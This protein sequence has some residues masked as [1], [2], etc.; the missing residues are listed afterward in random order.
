M[1]LLVN[2]SWFLKLGHDLRVDSE[3]RY[4]LIKYFHLVE[5]NEEGLSDIPRDLQ[6]IGLKLKI[7]SSN[8]AVIFPKINAGPTF[9]F[10]EDADLGS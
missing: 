6:L 5:E 4:Y 2:G 3:H 9:T 8:S 10:G 1:G 7:Q